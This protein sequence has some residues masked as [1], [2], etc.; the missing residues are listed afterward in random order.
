MG[1]FLGH[2]LSSIAL[3][4][5]LGIRIMLF[6]NEGLEYCLKLGSVT[7]LRTGQIQY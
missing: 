4:V 1:L 5:F 7:P 2:L 6:C 3:H